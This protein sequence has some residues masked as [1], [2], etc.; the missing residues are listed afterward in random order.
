MVCARGRRAR[1]TRPAARLH[2][3]LACGQN[4]SY[5]YSLSAFSGMYK[6]VLLKSLALGPAGE[7]YHESVSGLCAGLQLNG[8]LLALRSRSPPPRPDRLQSSTACNRV[9][10]EESR[11]TTERLHMDLALGDPLIRAH[12]AWGP[13]GVSRG[14]GLSLVSRDFVSNRAG[15]CPVSI[16]LCGPLYTSL[17]GSRDTTLTAAPAVTES[18]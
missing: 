4:G 10:A 13:H 12:G 1:H 8:A 11:E 14:D 16:S 7:Y 3:L 18:L 9:H 2:A 17:R 15:A 6:V 5:F